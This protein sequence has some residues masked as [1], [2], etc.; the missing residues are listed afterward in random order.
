MQRKVDT[1]REK[2]CRMMQQPVDITRCDHEIRHILRRCCSCLP[3]DGMQI[4]NR[5]DPDRNDRYA[6][7]LCAELC[8]AVPDTAA[9]D[10]A[11]DAAVLVLHSV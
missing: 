8:A 3:H 9:A 11:L 1:E 7:R 6:E 10:H 2:P 5:R 4:D